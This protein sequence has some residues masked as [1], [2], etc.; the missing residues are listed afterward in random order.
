MPSIGDLIVGGLYPLVSGATDT[1]LPLLSTQ[2][3]VA[4][5]PGALYQFNV[6]NFDQTSG[7]LILLL[8]QVAA[9]IS[10]AG[11]RPIDAYFI[12]AAT[13]TIPGQQAVLFSAIMSLLFGL[14][15]GLRPARR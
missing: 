13:A 14:Q 11:I 4:T 8:D 5:K 9:P 7:Y 3:Q 10:G 6:L 15:K 12:P 1:P 2:L